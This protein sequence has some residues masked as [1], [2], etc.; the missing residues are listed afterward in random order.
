[1]N[2]EACDVFDKLPD[3]KMLFP[4]M[5]LLYHWLYYDDSSDDFLLNE[6]IFTI[7]SMAFCLRPWI[8]RICRQSSRRNIFMLYNF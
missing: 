6:I 3:L 4:K 8:K 1:M 5:S 7:K 2:K